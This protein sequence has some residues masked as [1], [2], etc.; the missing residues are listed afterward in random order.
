MNSVIRILI[1]ILIYLIILSILYLTKPSMMF[2][3]KGYLK[4]IG[5]I[6]QGKSLFSIYLITPI[7]VIILYII[8]LALWKNI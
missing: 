5:Y 1:V 3:N 8:I 2:D 6:D 4:D 7:L